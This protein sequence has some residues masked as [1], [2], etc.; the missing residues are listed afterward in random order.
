MSRDNAIVV[1]FFI[2]LLAVAIV[3][4]VVRVKYIYHDSRCLVAECRISK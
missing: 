3:I 4:E 2:T 1:A